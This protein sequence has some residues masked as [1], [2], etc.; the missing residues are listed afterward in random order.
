MIAV[1]P[2]AEQTRIVNEVER[3]LSVLDACVRAVDT[4]LARSA[5][6]RRS[7]LK[8]AFEGRLV[9]QDPSDEPASALLERTRAE[10]RTSSPAKSGRSRKKVDAV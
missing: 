3:Q 2:V 10:R 5:A 9:P 4:G 7:V 6:L 8:A 1:P